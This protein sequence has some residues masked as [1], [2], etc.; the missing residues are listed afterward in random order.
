[1]VDSCRRIAVLA[2]VTVIDGIKRHAFIGLLLFALAGQAGGLLFFGF[3]P[4]DIG[5]V[6]NDF[7]FSVTFLAGFVF[8]LFHAVQVV[9][10]DDENRTIQTFLARPISR[11]E[12]LL[13]IFSGLALLLLFLNIIMGVIGWVVLQVI[14]NNVGTA[15]FPY[16]SFGFF[17]L[18][19]AGLYLLKLT[20]LAVVVFFASVIRGR[21]MVLLLTLAYYFICNGLPVVRESVQQ[22]SSQ[23]NGETMILL[24][25]VLSGIFPDFSRLDFKIL[26]VGGTSALPVA[27]YLLSFTV[28][29]L[30]IVVLLWLA[31]LSF[32]NKDM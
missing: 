29:L 19:F 1:M 31:A 16:L 9:S 24:F 23:S 17:L 6:A 14:Q 22:Q 30:Y 7:T 12:Y 28:S 11:T 10:L 25:Q 21:F 18:A 8:I 3:I 32:K 2:G 5:R 15:F 4:R 13:G 27:D 20:L 26:V